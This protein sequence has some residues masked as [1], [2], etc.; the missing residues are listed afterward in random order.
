[1]SENQALPLSGITVVE[2]GTYV[3]VPSAARLLAEYGARVIKVEPLDGDPWRPGGAGHQVT[4]GDFNAPLY[5]NQNSGKQ[6][7][8]LNTRSQA[9]QEALMRLLGQADVFVTNVRMKSLKKMGADYESIKDK[10][11]RLIYYH[12]SGFG[13][14]GPDAPRPGFDLAAFWARTGGLV[15]W[16]TEGDFPFRPSNGFGDLASGALV[17]NGIL[18]AL[19][20]RQ[21]TG[22]GTYVHSSLMSSSIWYHGNA[23][24]AAQDPY[25]KKFPEDPLRPGNPFFH[26]YRCKDGEWVVFAVLTGYP[27]NRA[28]IGE[29]LGLQ[30]VFADPRAATLQS[31]KETDFLPQVVSRMN[32]AFLTKTADEWCEIF[33]QNDFVYEK[34]GHLKDIATDPQA[35]ANGY[36]EPVTFQSGTTTMMPAAPITFPELG[37]VGTQNIGGVGQ[38]TA[39]ILKDL[40]YT[41]AEIAQ[42]QE[43]Q[44]VK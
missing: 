29:L 40:G 34:L 15:D 31:L 10:F 44:D 42:L 3:A 14:D 7:I 21:N 9:G 12:F 19:L 38:D 8:A 6:F 35:L 1:M 43:N 24:I 33:H 13:P 23:M 18:M 28:R 32:E 4:I 36:V 17:T 22:K 25:N 16:V 5:T 26:C 39:E 11:P 41:E 30:D 37:R 27:N 2:M 20:G